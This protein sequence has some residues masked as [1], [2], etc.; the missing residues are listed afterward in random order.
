[1]LQKLFGASWKTAVSGF[2]AGGLLI[3]G[4]VFDL[5]GVSVQNLTDGHFDWAKVVAG[6]GAFGIGWFA[7]DNGVT[8]EE[9]KANP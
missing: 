6:L 9:A 3:I 2:A 7:R 8:S 4:E 5:L 1:M